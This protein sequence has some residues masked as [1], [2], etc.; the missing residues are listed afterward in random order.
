MERTLTVWV[1]PA[2]IY[3]YGTVNG[4]AATFTLAGD[5]NWQAV[6]LRTEDDNYLLHLEAY[7]ANGLEGTYDYTLYYGMM[8]GVTD[9]TQADVRRLAVLT[10]KGWAAMSDAEKAEW[11]AGMKGAYNHTNLN[12]VGHNADYLAGLLIQYGYAVSIT[13]KTDWAVGDIPDA[14][15]MAVYLA[16]ITALKAAFYGTVVLPGTMDS[17]TWDGAN[18]I[19]LLLAEIDLN[20]K[21]M[22]ASWR[23][24][25]AAV[26]GDG[27]IL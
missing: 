8:P 1:G 4:E 16:N 17:L 23:Y 21:H 12:R 19:E 27:G 24:C 26:C 5:G 11:L 22:I 18:R 25:G 2:I 20:I 6:V 13:P 15:E 14:S 3:L 7:S 10:S 9:R